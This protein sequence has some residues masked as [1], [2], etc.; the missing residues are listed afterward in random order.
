MVVYGKLDGVGAE[1]WNKIAEAKKNRQLY[2]D[3]LKLKMPV[4]PIQLASL[5]LGLL[6]V[7]APSQIAARSISKSGCPHTCGNLS[8]PYPF[9]L[10][11]RAR[12][13]TY[14]KE[15]TPTVWMRIMGRDIAVTARKVTRGTLTCLAPTVV[16]ILISAKP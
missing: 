10:A 8:I 11:R 16:K 6:L 3:C 13:P 2:I 9:G 14:A 12:Q 1:P 4:V 15:R 5:Q 7:L